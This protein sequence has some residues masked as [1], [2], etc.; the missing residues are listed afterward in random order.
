MAA[1]NLRVPLTVTGKLALAQASTTLASALSNAAASN[2]VLKITTIRACNISAASSNI[3]VTVYRSSTHR[4]LVK[5]A[6]VDAGLSLIVT[7]REDYI[8]LEEGDA[9]Y[10]Q[11]SG[12]SAFDVSIAYEEVS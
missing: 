8:Y 6:P 9:I 4:Y 12:A 2:K 3:S 1:P 10:I 5:A 11:S 7:S